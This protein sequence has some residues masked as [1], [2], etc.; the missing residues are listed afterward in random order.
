MTHPT[1]QTV[2]L[3]GG[4]A[5]L[6]TALHLSHQ[7]Y[8]RSVILIDQNDRFCFKPLLYEYFSGEMDSTQVVPRYS[9]LLHHS[10]V[11][12]VQDAVQSIDLHQRQVQLVGG[13]CYSY[14]NLVLALG[15]TT[16]Y[17]GVE[18][19]KENAM[20]FRTQDD[21]IALDRHLRDRLQ[22]AA[23]LDDLEQR[24]RLL[25][26]AVI[27]AGPS[28]VEMA[29][30]LA[31]LLPQWYQAIGGNPEE[32]QVV[33][34]NHSQNILE[35]DINSQLRTTA[36]TALGQR[37]A[38][39]KF[40]LG[41]EVTAIRPNT[42]EYQYHG[43]SGILPAGTIIWTT[44]TNTHPLIKSLPIPDEHRD[45]HGRLHV[46]STLQ[47]PDFPEVF[48]GGDCAVDLQPTPA[49]HD[50]YESPEK[51]HDQST[52]A[53]E[54][55]PELKPLPPTAQVAYQQGAAIAQ[56]LRLLAL[57]YD[58]RPAKVSIRG[59]LLKLGL[60]ESVANIFNRV[61]VTGELGHLIRQGTYLE[62]L[63]TPIHD[64]KAT[65]EW[66]K[67]ELFE[68]HTADGL[69]QAA[70]VAGVVGGVVVGAIAAKKLLNALS[71]DSPDKQLAD[72]H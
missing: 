60:E 1:Y 6:F 24:R 33:L 67:D 22:R 49:E 48:A 58:L 71:H 42:V 12:F 63:P 70:K 26:T 64:F 61:E 3:G 2:I 18:G 44:G 37:A 8:P 41:A 20:P 43:Q 62:L 28:G 59:T 10:G 32:I 16:G 68:P 52:S 21:A 36:E 17:F 9:E 35:G 27:G 23:Q 11:I 5:G 50:S 39:V 13:D 15:S 65:A 34:I 29:A 56:N 69:K 7:H 46:T 66:L 19:A 25:T 55:H 30:T 54:Q 14:S 4:F 53:E 40:L 47:L 51:Q 38:P 72:Q 31:D 57:G 45:K